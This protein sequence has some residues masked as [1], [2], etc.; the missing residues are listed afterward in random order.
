MGQM[1]QQTSSHLSLLVVHAVLL[2][3]RHVALLTHCVFSNVLYY[4]YDP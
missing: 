4:L 1:E 2:T 3:Q